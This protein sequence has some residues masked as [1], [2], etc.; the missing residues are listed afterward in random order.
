MGGTKPCTEG[1][2]ARFYKWKTNCPSS[3][4]ATVTRL[5]LLNG[6]S[7]RSVNQ[8]L[9]ICRSFVSKSTT[10]LVRFG[11]ICC[12][13]WGYPSSAVPH[14]ANCNV[15][16]AKLVVW[17]RTCCISRVRCG[18][19]GWLRAL[20]QASRLHLAAFVLAA[21][22]AGYRTDSVRDVLGRHEH[23]LWKIY[24]VATPSH[25][26]DRFALPRHLVLFGGGIGTFGAAD[27]TPRRRVTIA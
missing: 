4:T 14:L 7:V 26:V 13:H 5:K 1:R 15:G 12:C 2:L 18:S 10:C 3:V 8:R 16:L 21:P 24:L 22:A 6:K 17:I 9:S 11:C 20:R 23:R 25:F 19:C 27:A